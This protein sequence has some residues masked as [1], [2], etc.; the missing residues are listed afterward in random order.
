MG[1]RGDFPDWCKENL[2][3][4]IEIV[5]RPS[6]WG[7]YLPSVEPPAM[8]PFTVLKRR[9][10]VERT[11]ARLGGNGRMSK[12]YEFLTKSERIIYLCGDESLDVEKIDKRCRKAE[13]LTFQTPFR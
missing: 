1:Y 10:V 2:G 12:D 3:W 13:I 4:T 9:W 5:K 6:K 11:I 7:R 8:P